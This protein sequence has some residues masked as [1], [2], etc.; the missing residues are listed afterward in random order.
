MYLNKKWNTNKVN[1]HILY[2]RD[3]SMPAKAVS[4]MIITSSY[5]GQWLSIF[6]LLTI[7]SEIYIFS[8]LFFFQVLENQLL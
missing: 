5:F 8:F 6:E 2:K 4:K 7:S 1:R 3:I